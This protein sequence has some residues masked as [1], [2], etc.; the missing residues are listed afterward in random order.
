MDGLKSVA[1]LAA[2]PLPTILVIGGI[3]FLFVAVVTVGGNISITAPKR[4]LSGVIGAVLLIAGVGLYLVPAPEPVPGTQTPEVA[5]AEETLTV[6]PIDE[7]APEEPAP[8]AEAPS[9]APE[10]IAQPPVRSEPSGDDEIGESELWVNSYPTGAAVYLA[11]A[12]VSIYDL[13]ISEIMTADNLIGD[14]PL[15]VDLPPGNYYIVTSFPAGLYTGSGVDIPANTDPTFDQAFPFDG[16]RSQTISFSGGVEVE[17]LS[18]VYQ[19]FKMAGSSKAMISVALP[20]PSQERGQP[21]PS[22]YPTLK[23]VQDLPAVYEFTGDSVKGSIE[24]NLKE[25]DL[26]QV[27]SPAL[28]DEMLA[29]LAHVGKVKLDTDEVDLIVQLNGLAGRTYSI[30]VFG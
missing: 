16:N 19:V 28:V 22:I 6:E 4:F 10:A 23:T 2:T 12:D 29:V 15:T 20:L 8:V 3:V 7:P 30:T 1:E 18:K 17:S 25:H 26:T 9:P 14:T 24:D 5:Q 11:P 27:V 13:E 21:N